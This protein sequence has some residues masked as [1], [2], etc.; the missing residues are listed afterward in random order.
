M[1]ESIDLDT[2]VIQRYSEKILITRYKNGATVHLEDAIEIDETH[3]ELSHG[4]EVF[5][6]VDM[7]GIE[8]KVSKRAQEYFTKKGKMIPKIKAVALI[9]DGIGN[10][11]MSRF[12]MQLYKPYYPT[13]IFSSR[14]RAIDW[15]DKLEANEKFDNESK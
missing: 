9:I 14:K 3:F 6:I 7:G 2:A 4:L 15:F 1:K 11:L 8:N 12:Y 5:T 13:K 10:R